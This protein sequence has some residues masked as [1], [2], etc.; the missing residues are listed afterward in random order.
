[1]EVDHYA[2][3]GRLHFAVDD[4]NTIT[5]VLVELPL[6]S[7]CRSEKRL[8]STLE[9]FTRDLVDGHPKPIESYFANFFE[10]IL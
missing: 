7:H 2:S 5:G 9:L 3:L 1:M 4:R 6:Q 8:K 10:R